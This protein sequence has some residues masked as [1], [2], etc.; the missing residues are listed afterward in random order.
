[1]ADANGRGLV[2]AVGECQ[3]FGTSTGYFVWRD[4]W[5]TLLRLDEHEAPADQI[6]RVERA[7]GELDPILLPRVPLLDAVLGLSIPDTELTAAFDPKL[8][9]TSLENLLVD[10]LRAR[11]ARDPLV[12]VLED[13]HWLDPL[14]RDLLDVVARSTT[15]AAVLLV[16]AYRPEAGELAQLPHMREV[17]L[18]PLDDTQMAQIVD[19]KLPQVLGEGVDAGALRELVVARAQ[20]NP[21]Y[22]E[23]LIHFVRD[24]G[25]DPSDERALRALELPESLHSL[26]LSRIDTLAEA[27]RSQLK[28][29]SVVGR[30]FRAPM[31]PSVYP[32][33]GDVE[34]V[35]ADL[36][37]LRRVDLVDLDHEEDESY[38]F[39]NAMTQEVAYESLPYALRATLHGQVGRYLEQSAAAER[40]L[41]L[42]AHH[43]WHSDDQPKKRLYLGLA[44]E[45]AQASYANAAA[46]DYYERLHPLLAGA[47]QVDALLELGKVLELV[48][49]WERA[50]TTEE[51]ALELAREIGDDRAV[52]RS[53]AALA[54]VARKQNHFDE[55][56]D[57]LARAGAAF[58]ALGDDTGLGR[59]LHLEGTI[60]AQ[61][62][63]LAEARASYEESLTI[64]RR[65]GDVKMMASVLS[66]LGVV[67]EYEGDYPLA[68]SLHEQA[69]ELRS[70][71]ADRWAIAVSMTNLGMIASIEGLHDE[72]RERFDEAMRL[73]SEVGDSWSVAISHNNLGNANRDLGRYDAAREHYAESL[74]A[75]NDHDDRWA[76]AFLLEDVGRLAALSGQPER[77][78]EL[79]GSADIM[80]EQIGAPRASSLEQEIAAAIEP[81][82]SL[83][84]GTQRAAARRR[85][86]RFDRARAI[87]AGLSI[88]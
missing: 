57:L 13:C 79:V 67:A 9:K 32:E 4:I 85:G 10:L 87:E 84:T 66:N 54:E 82:A 44:A 43:Y 73:N 7:V 45:A 75:H 6:T 86:R 37:A 38:L 83:L 80:R 19:A 71:L 23:E 60:A 40:Q 58:G 1:M 81:A 34:D 30:V 26:I 11:A 77:A 52:A 24:R 35:R 14:S 3:S 69:L 62:G 59:V 55:A 25:L 21:F 42:L 48:G 29:A 16:V 41:D 2:V 88:S 12:L 27:P 39:K 53:E 15:S 65:L 68:R 51:G 56:A 31:L 76:L 63:L 20:G 50:R 22:A 5:R 28:V 72:A 49:Q 74:R 17:V 64:R 33:L 36:G 61:R 47:A 70:A 78:L 46:I 18:E 8:R